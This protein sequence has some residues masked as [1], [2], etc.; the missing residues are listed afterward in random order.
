M[1][2]TIVVAPRTRTAHLKDTLSRFTLCG[3]DALAWQWPVAWQRD[4]QVC[5]RGSGAET[6]ATVRAERAEIKRQQQEQ[7]EARRAAEEA[8][9]W[10]RFRAYKA[11]CEQVL[12]RVGAFV[13]AQYEDCIDT[14]TGWIVTI[15][16]APVEIAI[17][18]ER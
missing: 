14:P 13:R 6:F 7:A 4:C 5:G 9:M 12:A 3:R 11:A 16:G 10:E 2:L 15:D 1:S 18:G 17:G 8:A